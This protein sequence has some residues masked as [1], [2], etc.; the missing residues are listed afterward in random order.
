MNGLPLGDKPEYRFSGEELV[1]E[2]QR[3]HGKRIE[4]YDRSVS[5]GSMS[6]ERADRLIAM[7]AA[8]IA[9][10][11]ATALGKTFTTPAP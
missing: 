6:R 7:A 5:A 8:I 3:E 10:L 1:R 2:M 9:H 11:Q 4:V